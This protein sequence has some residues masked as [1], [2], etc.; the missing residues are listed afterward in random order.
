M[1]PLGHLEAFLYVSSLL[2]GVHPQLSNSSTKHNAS[3][4]KAADHYFFSISTNLGSKPAS[5]CIAG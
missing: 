4:L 2:W 5:C 1:Q 3:V